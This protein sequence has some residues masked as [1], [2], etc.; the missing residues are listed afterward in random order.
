MG[1][2]ARQRGRW[3]AVPWTPFQ[4][5]EIPANE[6]M[7]T[8]PP[9]ALLVNSRYQVSVWVRGE[10][11]PF[12]DIV[13][14]SLKT[15]DRAAYHDWRDMQRIKNEIC[16]PE[17]EAVEIYPAESRLVD[18][19][20]QYHLFV[21]RTYKLPFGYSERLV[22]DGAWENS[23]QRPFPPGERPADCLDVEQFDAA[24]KQAYHMVRDRKSAARAV[25]DAERERQDHEPERSA[26]LHGADA[27]G[28]AT[29]VP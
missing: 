1:R 5:V 26:G 14:L 4:Q 2:E 22:A 10:L 20:N 27:P 25:P 24:F 23:K 15:H 16:G 7:D 21:F 18:T 13:H 28:P 12:G 3:S 19:A 8:D 6:L 9:T 11:P 17:C 29:D